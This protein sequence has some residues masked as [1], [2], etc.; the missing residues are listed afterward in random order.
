M[1]KRDSGS[2]HGGSEGKDG[3]PQ[4]GRGGHGHGF[5]AVLLLSQSFEL[6]QVITSF[7]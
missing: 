1:L 7:R 3:M 4:F 5:Q 6:V 2:G